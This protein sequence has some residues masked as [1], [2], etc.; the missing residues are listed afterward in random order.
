MTPDRSG[1]NTRTGRQFRWS[2]PAIVVSGLLL[3]VV[4]FWLVRQ[5]ELASFHARLESDVSQR[6]DTIINKI[7]DSL[8]V[9]LALGADCQ[10]L[11]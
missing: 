9:V 10:S 6:T 11:G 1:A 7:D 4:L 5:A 3:T 2:V 8:L